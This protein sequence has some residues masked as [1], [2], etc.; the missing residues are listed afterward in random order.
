MFE[1]T[2]HEMPTLALLAGGLATR[3]RP[4]TESVAKSML[5]VAGSPFI[6]HQLRMLSRQGITQVVICCGHLEEQIRS[7]VGYGDEFGCTITYSGDGEQPLGTG[8]A[9]RNALPLLGERFL[10]MYGDSYL[11]VEI[12]PVWRSFLL[13]GK[14]GLMTVYRNGNKWDTSNV[15]FA[16]GAIRNY[17]KAQPTPAM[18]HIDYGLNCMRA[19]ALSACPG[20]SR[21]DL[22]QVQQMLLAQGQLAGF[23]VCERFYEIGSPTGF[24]ETDTLLRTQAGEVR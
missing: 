10:I 3:M 4:A 9:L 20:G 8:G 11:P 7:Y 14:Q 17:S 13:S 18:H 21:F 23:E 2:Q 19:E 6:G 12:G 15:E 22:A 24:A 1:T 5:R 16:G